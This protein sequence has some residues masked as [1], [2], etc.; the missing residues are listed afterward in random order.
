MS[1]LLV[2]RVA[3]VALLRNR[4][5]TVLTT[6]GIAIG[7]A[8][9]VC[10]VA[11]GQGSAAQ[12]HQRFLDLGDNFIWI[13][14][15]SRN[16]GGVRTGSGGVP[17]LTAD[18][19]AA[20][21]AD[22]PDVVR[23]SPNVNG[24]IQLIRGDQNWNTRYRGVSPDY[25]LV[26]AWPVVRGTSF[27]DLDVQAH[28]KVAVLGATVAEELFGGDNPVGQQFRAGPLVFTAVGV[29][30]ARGAAAGDNQD[31][32]ILIPYTTAQRNLKGNESRVDDIMCSARTTAAIKPA[33]DGIAALLRIR[34]RIGPDEPDDFNI[35]APDDAIRLQEASAQTM[36]LMISSVAS[37]SLIVG[38]IGVMNI[39]LVSVTERT[40]EIGLRMALGARQFDVQLQFLAE[41]IALGLVGGAVGVLL[42]VAGAAIFSDSFGFPMI[43]APATV[44]VATSFAA[45]VGL[46]F[47]FYPARRA[48][49]LD[50]IDAL[51]IE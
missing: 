38:G 10:T 19:A 40:R 8:A 36:E 23:C 25:M 47:G 33:Q 26:K 43:I 28:A 15:G 39:M 37:V 49:G 17:R 13:E 5:R 4:M 32:T 42:A 18:D 34:H 50:P 46:I 48:A 45:S 11:L 2:A 1:W 31:D 24:R 29:L 16:V 35:R 41:A 30:D 12:I 14:N 22:V 7:I 20:F 27:D 3:M 9:V 44:A 21:V 6:L 51:R